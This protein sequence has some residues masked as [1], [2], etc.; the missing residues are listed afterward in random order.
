MGCRRLFILLIR[1]RRREGRI[2]SEVGLVEVQTSMGVSPRRPQSRHRG[3]LFVP[4][5]LSLA[6]CTVRPS[7]RCALPPL[8]V[9]LCGSSRRRRPVRSGAES[10][11]VVS[12]RDGSY[13]S[14]QALCLKP[15][16]SPRYGLGKRSTWLVRVYAGLMA[17]SQDWSWSI[18]Q[19][20]DALPKYPTHDT[21]SRAARPN[22]KQTEPSK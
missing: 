4:W 19:R 18:G 7:S 10:C 20:G 5:H 22:R 16:E 21:S 8:A 11:R 6:R 13:G 14:N 17:V 2:S 3:V 15:L 12:C 9:V 1:V